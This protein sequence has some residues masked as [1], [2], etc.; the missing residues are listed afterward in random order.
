MTFAE[1]N[2]LMRIAHT[3]ALKKAGSFEGL[4]RVTRARILEGE[5]AYNGYKFIP[6]CDLSLQG[7][8]ANR[9]WEH[10][11]RLAIYLNVP[12]RAEIEWRNNEKSAYPGERGLL[13]F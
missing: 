5:F 12:L 8:D 3:E 4:R 13:F 1:W 7:V 6:E 11:L 2:E 9:A 10:S